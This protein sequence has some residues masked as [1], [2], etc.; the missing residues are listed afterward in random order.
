MARPKKE[1]KINICK[2]PSCGKSFETIP[3]LIRD[4]CSKSC[5]QK[6]KAE[7]NPECWEK[8]KKTCLEKYGDEVAF[9]SKQVQDKYKNNLIKKYGVDN[10]FLVPEFKE[11]SDK[12]ILKK[13]GTKV[14]NMNK[15]IGNKISDSLKNKPKNRINFVEV[16]WEKI[17]NYCNEVNMTP[18]FTKEELLNNKLQHQYDNK[19]K[20][21]CNNCN[22]TTVV[23]LSNGYFPSCDCSNYKGYSLIEEEIYLYIKSIIND[24]ILLK[25]RDIL[26]NRLELD[27]FIPNRNIA[28]EINGI[29]WHSE[30]M[31]KYKDYHIYKTEKC[32]EKNI[33]LI[34]IFDN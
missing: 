10:P 22:N 3:S 27:I 31:G 28:I 34:H 2:F 20:F 25:N 15:E 14:A 30:S 13:Y 24:T 9:R 6:Y 19:F 33:Q 12:T 11:K 29:Y 32:E 17:L 21:I 7:Y 8:R 5:A 1:K 4:F 23:S 26:P 18:L 16:K